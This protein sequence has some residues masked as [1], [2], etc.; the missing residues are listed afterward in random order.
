MQN[1]NLVNKELVKSY[2][3]RKYDRILESISR[4]EEESLIRSPSIYVSS[5]TSDGVVSSSSSSDSTA[6]YDP[7]SS[8]SLSSSSDAPDLP[9]KI[10]NRRLLRKVAGSLVLA[11]IEKLRQPR[12]TT[13]D[14]DKIGSLDTANDVDNYPHHHT[15]EDSSKR[16]YFLDIFL[17][18][19]TEGVL[20]ESLPQRATLDPEAEVTKFSLSTLTTNFQKLGGH[21]Q[22]AFEFQDTLIKLITWRQPAKTLSFLVVVTLLFYRPLY[23]VLVPLVF[24]M[25]VVIVPRYTSIHPSRRGA[26]LVELNSERRDRHNGRSLL[27]DTLSFSIDTDVKSKNG[28]SVGVVANLRDLQSFTTSLIKI[29][30]SGAAV[31]NA[32]VRFNDEWLTTVIFLGSL[33]LFLVLKIFGRLINWSLLFS[34]VVCL[35]VTLFHPV[36]YP[37]TIGYHVGYR[38]ENE[39]ERVSEPT[40]QRRVNLKLKSGIIGSLLGDVLE[41][42][43]DEQPQTKEVEIFEIDKEGVVPGTWELFMFSSTDFGLNDTFRKAQRQPPGVDSLRAVEAPQGWIFDPNSKWEIDYDVKSWWESDLEGYVT[44]GEYLVDHAFRRRRLTRRVIRVQGT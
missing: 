17:D 32:T 26:L 36:V 11:S 33:A 23:F 25:Y 12:T 31:A 10:S 8:V 5:G 40:L 4:A 6:P 37:Y 14:K 1:S 27:L 16:S 22:A 2:I 7:Y 38:C 19:L 41:I 21:L 34:V 3:N 43:A 35:G 29:I 18:K 28:T 39:K 20:P 15:N 42:V 44:N 9:S 24:L 30:D 13:T